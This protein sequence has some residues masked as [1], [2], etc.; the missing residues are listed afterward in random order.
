MGQQAIG[1]QGL[2]QQAIGQQAVG[3]Q[4]GVTPIGQQGLGQQPIGQVTTGQE[5]AGVG[6]PGSG[7]A[8]LVHF[9]DE[10][11]S[12]VSTAQ[13]ASTTQTVCVLIICACTWLG[14]VYE[15]KRHL[16]LHC[17]YKLCNQVFTYYVYTYM[18]D[19]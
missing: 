14:V 4:A 9:G 15:D 2:G 6:H 10:V 13:Q 1:Q 17:M 12:P 18:P 8:T 5:G 3:Q 7:V 11:S 19:L 16:K